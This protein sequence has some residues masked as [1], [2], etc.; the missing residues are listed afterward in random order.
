MNPFDKIDTS[1]R[2]PIM[3]PKTIPFNIINAILASAY[4]SLKFCRTEYSRNCAL[5]D[6]AVL[7]TLFATG[8]R[9]SEICT[10]TPDAIDLE[11]HTLKIFGKGSKERIIQIENPDVLKA[12]SNYFAVF[13]DDISCA[14]FFFVN[15]LKHRLSEQS[16]RAMI[17]RYVT[18][19]ATLLRI[20][21]G[22]HL[23]PYCLKRTWISVIFKE[24]SGI[25]PLLQHRST[26]M[27]PWQSR[28][29][30]YL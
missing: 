5:R 28:R 27:L 3:L 19:N 2:E 11:N 18:S 15:K 6:I 20:C 1:F 14:G 8:A 30:F 16:V 25:A 17:N 13:Q 21:L 4:G 7:E 29:K 26:L 12:L 10:L 9:V 23:Q 22:I 24:Y